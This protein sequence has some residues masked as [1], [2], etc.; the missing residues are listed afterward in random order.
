MRAGAVFVAALVAACGAET[1]PGLLPGETDAP[2]CSEAVASSAQPTEL[3]CGA[4]AAVVSC[5]DSAGTAETCISDDPTRCGTISTGCHDDCRTTGQYG[6]ACHGAT[7]NPVQPPS[8]CVGVEGAP[9]GTY[10]YCCPC[11]P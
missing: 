3:G 7:G 6:V 8:G 4:A 1:E 5:V 2:S 9:N 11:A 10:Y